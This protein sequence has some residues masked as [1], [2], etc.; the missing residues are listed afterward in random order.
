MRMIFREH[1]LLSTGWLRLIIRQLVAV[2][3]TEGLNHI[4]DFNKKKTFLNCG[5]WRCSSP[6]GVQLLSL[7]AP[8]FRGL[9][10]RGEEIPLPEYHQDCQ[11][12]E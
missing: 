9:H 11:K 12:L 1:Q 4:V 3:A 10:I 7:S 8:F 2:S 5:Q 6:V